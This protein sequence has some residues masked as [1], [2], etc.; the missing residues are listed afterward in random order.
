MIDKN[1]R[2]RRGGGCAVLCHVWGTVV[3]L[4][5]R[6]SVATVGI[7]SFVDADCHAPA[8]LAMTLG[9]AWLEISAPREYNS[10]K[11]RPDF[12]KIRGGLTVH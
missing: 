4:S 6:G 2:L 3:A 5:F 11:Q 10:I 8:A 12:A 1:S 7:R 9:Q